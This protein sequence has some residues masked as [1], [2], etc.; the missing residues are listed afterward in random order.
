MVWQPNI[1]NNCY[2]LSGGHA[3][4][5]TH[6]ELCPWTPLGDFRSPD[7]LCPPPPNPGYVTVRCGLDSGVS[8]SVR[9]ESDV[10]SGRR[11]RATARRRVRQPARRG[12]TQLRAVAQGHAL[13]PRQVRHAVA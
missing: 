5:T 4:R 8:A 7:S 13:A 6:Q 11:R 2:E 1:L 10:R 9:H 3:P 12:R